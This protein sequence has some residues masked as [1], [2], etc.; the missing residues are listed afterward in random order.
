[1]LLRFQTGWK[2]ALENLEG[3]GERGREGGKREREFFWGGGGG[4][5]LTPFTN[6]HPLPEHEKVLDHFLPEVVID[7]VDLL[8][9]EETG[10]MLAQFR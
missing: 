4:G 8:L 1:M 9:L 6:H 2:I 5:H 3:G 10:K 7:A